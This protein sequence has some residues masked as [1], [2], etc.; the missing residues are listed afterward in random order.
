MEELK[1]ARVGKNAYMSD[2]STIW[3]HKNDEIEQTTV[4]GV[5][6]PEKLM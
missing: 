6:L 1:N 3:K 5:Q 4:S 2:F